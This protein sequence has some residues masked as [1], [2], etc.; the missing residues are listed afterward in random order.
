MPLRLCVELSQK[1]LLL[2]ALFF[3]LLPFYLLSVPYSERR[4]PSDPFVTGD[5][6]RAYCDYVYDEED[7]TLDPA[8]VQPGSA[9]FVKTDMID[10]F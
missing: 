10:L 6:F 9:I 4:A 5:G 8:A 3:L 1:S 7:A 2:N